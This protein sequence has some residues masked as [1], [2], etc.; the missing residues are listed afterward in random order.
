MSCRFRP[1]PIIVV[2]IIQF[3]HTQPGQP[4]ILL[5]LPYI[6][7]QVFLKQ[8]APQLQPFYFPPPILSLK[9]IAVTHMDAVIIDINDMLEVDP[10]TRYVTVTEGSIFFV[11]NI[12]VC[13]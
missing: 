12:A 7:L 4:I 13:S 6:F 11:D 8:L 1:L 10:Y 3:F 5:T 9:T 2:P